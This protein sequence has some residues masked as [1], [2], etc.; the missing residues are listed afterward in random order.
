[1][2]PPGPDHDTCDDNSCRDQDD[3]QQAVQQEVCLGGRDVGR[4][5]ALAGDIQRVGGILQIIKDDGQQPVVAGANQ[6]TG[7]GSRIDEVGVAQDNYTRC[8]DSSV[9]LGY[10]LLCQNTQIEGTLEV[11]LFIDGGIVGAAL[12]DS[13]VRC[14]CKGADLDTA[15]DIVTDRDSGRQRHQYIAVRVTGHIF[16]DLTLCREDGIDHDRD[17]V[18]TAG[19]GLQHGTDLIVKTVAAQQFLEVGQFRRIVGDQEQHLAAVLQ[20]VQKGLVLI[21]VDV[22]IGCIHQN[23]R[24]G[25]A[26]KFGDVLV[27]QVHGLDFVVRIAEVIQ[28]L[29]AKRSLAVA[30]QLIKNRSTVQAYILDGGGDGFLGGKAGDL[31]GQIGGVALVHEH[32]ADRDRTELLAGFIDDDQTSVIQRSGIIHQELIDESRVI[33]GIDLFKGDSG[34]KV[35]VGFHQLDDHDVGAVAFG[36]LVVE[37]VDRYVVLQLIQGFHGLVTRCIQVVRGHIHAQME[38]GNEDVHQD[39]GHQKD[40][41]GNGHIAA[42]F[43]GFFPSLGASVTEFAHDIPSLAPA[44]LFHFLV[45]QEKEENDHRK[46]EN[47]V[48]E[49]KDTGKDVAEAFKHGEFLHDVDQKSVESR[50]NDKERHEQSKQTDDAHDAGDDHLVDRPVDQKQNDDQCNDQS[51]ER[52]IT[53]AREYVVQSVGKVHQHEEHDR[54]D[55]SDQLI[56]C[57]GRDEHTDGD[58]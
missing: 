30:F 34:R 27:D 21:V 4:F 44:F 11:A 7:A 15:G 41:G 37:A 49:F 45:G 55:G 20:E 58:K 50:R 56:F 12:D 28:E 1:M 33:Q 36:S 3:E 31:T 8:T 5:D 39:Q 54:N 16:G 6:G 48:A 29:I 13:A 52:E 47:H 42:V 53:G 46:E 57:Q 23:D 19:I 51:T 22:L 26:G 9:L 43:E 2:F 14:R 10:G 17:L 40:H 35:R 38:L 32:V 24:I 25:I 18:I